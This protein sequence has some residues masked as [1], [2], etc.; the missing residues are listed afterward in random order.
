MTQLEEKDQKY[1]F[2]TLRLVSPKWRP[3]ANQ[4]EIKEVDII[5]KNHPHDVERCLEETLRRWIKSDKSSAETLADALDT[6]E[7][8]GLARE[9]RKKYNCPE[10]GERESYRYATDR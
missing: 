6:I 5:E 8:G 4:L 1:L 7:E 3:L 10:K 9:V 2:G